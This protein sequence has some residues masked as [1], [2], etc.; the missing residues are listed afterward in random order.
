MADVYNLISQHQWI[1][2]AAVLIGA[3][4][5]ALKEDTPIPIT[6]PPKVRPWLALG[7]GATAGALQKVS[8]GTP[9]KEAAF[10]GILAGMLAIVG[11]DTIVES[12][13]DPKDP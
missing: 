13:R 11:H 2:L 8:G 12:L 10:G 5:R 4:V 6:I 9:W 3:L 1:G 7:L